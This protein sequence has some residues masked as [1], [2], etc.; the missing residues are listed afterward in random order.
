MQ[1]LR[2]LLVWLHQLA[3]VVWIGQLV[4]TNVV[5]MP[6][7]AEQLKGPAM[8]KMIG[9][10]AKRVTPLIWGSVAMFMI[11]GVPMTVGRMSQAGIGH[12][13]SVLILIKHALVVLMIVLGVQTQKAA[14]GAPAP[15]GPPAD[16]QAAIG[17]SRLTGTA[18]M[19]CGIIVLLLTA[20]AEAL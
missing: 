15:A 10:M 13:W 12:P 7:F 16:V 18:S 14:A 8:G 1:A 6:L 20:V 19:I 9:A 2:V 11:T 4:L 3:T 17:R 5:Y